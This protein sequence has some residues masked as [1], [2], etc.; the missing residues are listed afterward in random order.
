[1]YKNRYTEAALK[2]KGADALTLVDKQRY[3]LLKEANA[4]L[5]E[6]E[7]FEFCI[8]QAYLEVA[9]RGDQ[10]K[11]NCHFLFAYDT[12]GDIL[13][14][15]YKKQLKKKRN[16]F[17]SLITATFDPVF[18]TSEYE[19]HEDDPIVEKQNLLEIP[20]AWGVTGKVN[21]NHE[22]AYYDYEMADL[23]RPAGY[24]PWWSSDDDEH[25]EPRHRG[26]NEPWHVTVYE[27]HFL[28]FWP[29]AFDAENINAMNG[30]SKANAVSLSDSEAEPS[31]DS[32]ATQKPV[33]K[34]SGKPKDFAADYAKSSRSQC[35]LC[36]GHIAK[37][38][39]RLGINVV[40]EVIINDRFIDRNVIFL[41]N[42]LLF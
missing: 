19:T 41:F 38:I 21:S 24:N 28:V 30:V 12:N 8:F 14:R 37:D 20:H 13:R 11:N 3:D 6:S 27:G 39:F 22:D 5:P 32:A 1:L 2:K 25:P 35:R 9:E 15:W 42:N 26:K 34:K 40:K 23:F 31:A 17:K 10:V 16:T 29:R 4:L 7:Q 36:K 33:P 18:R